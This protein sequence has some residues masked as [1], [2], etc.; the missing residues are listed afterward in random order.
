MKTISLSCLR[1][2][3]DKHN[4][5]LED[6]LD[7][8]KDAVN[9]LKNKKESIRIRIKREASP[10]KERTYR[11]TDWLCKADR[12]E[13]ETDK[14][15]AEGQE[16]L[17]R[18]EPRCCCANCFCNSNSEVGK[19]V[20]E[21]LNSVNQ[22]LIE[23]NFDFVVQIRPHDFVD[24]INVEATVDFESGLDDVWRCVE[25]DSFRIIGIYGM[26]GIG[27]TTLLKKIKD[28]LL[29]RKQEFEKVIWVEVSRE[30]NVDAIQ[31]VIRKQLSIS[32]ETW[33]K[34]NKR[35]MERLLGSKKFILLLDDLWDRLDL[36]KF[37]VPVSDG[38]GSKVIFT[39]RSERVCDE[40]KAQKKL[41]LKCLSREQALTLF[42]S[43]VG[44]N[45][46]NFTDHVAD[47]IN[48]EFCQGL[49]L[50]LISI[51]Q[52]MSR[53]SNS[54]V[55][56]RISTL[57]NYPSTFP[58]M[59]HIFRIIEPS[60][61]SL[62]DDILKN[63]F[64][65]TCIL[66]NLIRKD[67][68]IKLWIGE[69][70][71][72]MYA[73][74]LGD[75]VIKRLKASCLLEGDES[76]DIFWMHSVIRTFGL[77]LAREHG[78]KENKVL[79]Q[80]RRVE[81]WTEAVRISIY[82]QKNVMLPLSPCPQV[83]TLLIRYTNLNAFPTGLQSM[84]ALGVLDL[85]KNKNLSELPSGIGSLINL[86]YLNLSFTSI[87]ELPV[88]MKNLANLRLLLMDY[89]ENFQ[90]IPKRLISSF[91]SLQV[92]NKLGDKIFEDTTLLEELE[93]IEHLSDI[94]ISLFSYSAAERM[95]NSLQSCIRNLSLKH[96]EKLNIPI[97]VLSRLVHL[98]EL[99]IE[100]CEDLRFENDNTQYYV[101]NFQSLRIR[102]CSKIYDLRWLIF[103]PK[104]RTLDLRS[105]ESLF[106]IVGNDFESEEI[107]EID[108]RL[109]I[110]PSLKK[111]YLEDLQHL[112][113]ICHQALQFPVLM[114]IVVIGCP[115]LVEL[116]FH[117]HSATRLRDIKG[118]KSWW[119]RL[120]WEDV[121]IRDVFDYKFQD[122]F[123]ASQFQQ[124]HY[125][126]TAS[127]RM[128]RQQ[129]GSTAGKLL[130]HADTAPSTTKGKG[131]RKLISKSPIAP[132]T[133]QDRRP[134][135]PR[136]KRKWVFKSPLGIRSKAML[137]NTK[138]E[139]VI[140]TKRLGSSWLK[141]FT[142]EE[143]V[144]ATAN[145]SYGSLLG[146]GGSGKV[147]KGMLSNG[148]AVAVKHFKNDRE[149]ADNEFLAEIETISRIHHRNIVKLVGYCQNQANKLLVY[150]FV[151][152]NSLR[153]HLFE[154]DNLSIDW[155]IR[156]KIA[157]GSA[158]GLTYLH[159]ECEPRIVHRNINP[160]NIL[161]DHSFEPKILL[162][163]FTRKLWEL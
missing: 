85:S 15:I 162:L 47:T 72:D 60:F 53:M 9:E 31:N 152:N 154:N 55:E 140:I 6:N 142:Y 113:H 159:E 79:V 134:S 27:K 91:S 90:V 106:E 123:G 132:K 40:M 117:L 148:E 38:S 120:K 13:T 24:L 76:S 17:L 11:V 80:E 130:S 59:N 30:A 100:G 101:L 66:P 93:S 4:C 104:I 103:A 3:W 135:N 102:G 61:D 10:Y 126:R 136:G 23:G 43:K 147:Y 161:L 87:K 86:Q 26:A 74:N 139:S 49:P 70:I 34:T 111:L 151:P 8:L 95:L 92:F 28:E 137:S 150:E 116:P 50:A 114:D 121:A 22:I 97:S 14:V 33:K 39:T 58:G 143:L 118:A 35:D 63:C 89:T 94:S 160:S 119:D 131:K 64:I 41:K 54:E 1:P 149:T 5:R 108:T 158:K 105:C 36:L 32:N 98:E 37:G 57:Q 99:D 84:N 146:E 129:E 110:L 25:D 77:W 144:E 52:A 69:G 21:K 81:K 48:T 153:Y 88:E 68:V 75:Y 56:H 109:G 73:K 71:L 115:N 124:I 122:V 42:R 2:I 125:S 163:K 65:H 44:L 7:S 18:R 78:E 155:S 107:K 127:P 67:E 145:F 112:H 141:T 83:R 133:I 96:V 51:A 12:L 29:V 16:E 62:E 156:M 138:E 157:V 46:S 20:W 82:D 45:Y 128:N 19:R